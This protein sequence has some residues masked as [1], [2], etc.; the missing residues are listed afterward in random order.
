M[1]YSEQQ[2]AAELEP[3]RDRSG[4]AAQLDHA[5]T[6]VSDMRLVPFGK[7]TAIRRAIVLDFP[8]L[9]LMLTIVPPGSDCR[10]IHKAIFLTS[11]KRS[12]RL[13]IAPASFSI[14]FLATLYPA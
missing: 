12:E 1:P 14:Y 11:S 10:S 2:T 8:F 13:V 7:G 9:P 6:S 4:R 3:S 5:Y